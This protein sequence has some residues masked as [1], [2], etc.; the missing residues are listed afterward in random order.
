MVVVVAS[1]RRVAVRC[2]GTGPRR[3]DR[4][5]TDPRPRLR[6]SGQPHHVG[7]HVRPAHHLP[8]TLDRRRESVSSRLRAQRGDVLLRVSTSELGAV[9]PATLGSRQTARR[10][11]GLGR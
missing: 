3:S 11:L 9:L 8:A 5:T 6:G 2:R 1:Q 4:R 10:R 7:T